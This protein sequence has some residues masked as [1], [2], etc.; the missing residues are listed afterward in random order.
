MSINIFHN[1]LI[2]YF[3]S[4]WRNKSSKFTKFRIYVTI[5]SSCI[6]YIIFIS[7]YVIFCRR[8]SRLP[9]LSNRSILS[10][11]GSWR[12]T[13]AQTVATIQCAPTSIHDVTASMPTPYFTLLT[14]RYRLPS[15]PSQF[16][17][18]HPL[19]VAFLFQ[20]KGFF[21]IHFFF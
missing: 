8:L 20:V 9:R 12:Q 2:Q 5:F 19:N 10:Q 17:N 6:V 21:C 11:P 16:V 15:A 4:L 7:P 13:H 14:D 1:K 3:L 18:C